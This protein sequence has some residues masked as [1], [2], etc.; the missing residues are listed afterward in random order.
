MGAPIAA[1]AR[2]FVSAQAPQIESGEFTPAMQLLTEEELAQRVES[3]VIRRAAENDTVPAMLAGQQTGTQESGEP[4]A[5][6]PSIPNEVLN[7]EAGSVDWGGLPAPWEPLPG[8]PFSP[9]EP[10]E[11]QSN[12]GWFPNV[13]SAESS[14]SVSNGIFSGQESGASLQRAERGREIAD[15]P[16]TLR[17]AMQ[18]EIPAAPDLDGLARQVYEILKRR[19]AAERRRELF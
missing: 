13:A 3:R 18:P 8:Q 16:A 15:F 19:L 9:S 2:R 6:E 7:A 10:A 12:Q 17:A 1:S 14:G 5:S 4:D 11:R